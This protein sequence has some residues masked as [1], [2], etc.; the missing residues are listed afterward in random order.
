MRY[1]ILFDFGHSEPLS[2]DGRSFKNEAIFTELAAQLKRLFVDDNT[3]PSRRIRCLINPDQYT[4]TF[5][6]VD[7]SA[8]NIHVYRA[9]IKPSNEHMPLQITTT[10]T[11]A[12][13]DSSAA[14]T[15]ASAAISSSSV[16]SNF[17]PS[18]VRWA[19]SENGSQSNKTEFF[20][21]WDTHQLFSYYMRKQNRGEQDARENARRGQA[22]FRTEVLT[23]LF[24]MTS[25][26]RGEDKTRQVRWE[27]AHELCWSFHT[28]CDGNFLRL[29]SRYRM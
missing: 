11:A 14:S 4:I 16:G 3:H 24:V 8:T 5:N 6:K 22:K 27:C 15:T 10:I 21:E 2:I 12:T 17:S 13:T 25:P 9:V 18:I 23:R 26:R 19:T 1:T 29:G 20:Y 7:T 28:A